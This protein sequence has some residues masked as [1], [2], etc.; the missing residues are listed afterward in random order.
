MIVVPID[1]ISRDNPFTREKLMPVT[2]LVTVAS[3]EV[4]ISLCHE[5]LKIEGIGHSAAIHSGNRTLID[6]FSTALPVS[7]VLVNCP[8]SQGVGGLYTGLVPSF[9]LT[10]SS[11]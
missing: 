4:G 3:D 6:R 1:R 9:T 2:S 5:L 10:A 11:W 7:R 8:A